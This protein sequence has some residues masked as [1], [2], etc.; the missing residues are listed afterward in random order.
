[1]GQWIVE[2]HLQHRSRAGFTRNRGKVSSSRRKPAQCT[3]TR[4]HSLIGYIR[5]KIDIPEST[6]TRKDEAPKLNNQQRSKKRQSPPQISEEDQGCHTPPSDQVEKHSSKNPQKIYDN[7]MHQRKRSMKTTLTKSFEREESESHFPFESRLERTRSSTFASIRDM[8]IT[9]TIASSWMTLLRDW[10]REANC[11]SAWKE[12]KEKGKSLP[13]LNLFVKL[14]KLGPIAKIKRPTMG[15]RQ[16]IVAITG[17]APLVNL[18]S[19]GTMGRNIVKM[20]AF[21]KKD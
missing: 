5:A 16:H 1:M 14:P 18:P 10:S 19:K 9:L 11:L 3:S 8:A 2:H 13:R 21:H 17:G 12:E 20:L 6:T 7:W 15:K 4:K